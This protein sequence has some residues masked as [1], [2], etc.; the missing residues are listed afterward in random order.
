MA[1]LSGTNI[2]KVS[3]PDILLAKHGDAEGVLSLVKELEARGLR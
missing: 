2:A 3:H 1:S